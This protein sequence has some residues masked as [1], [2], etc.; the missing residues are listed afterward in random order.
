[1][2]TQT[3]ENS[4]SLGE[5]AHQA[6]RRSFKKLT[7]SEQSVLEDVD[8]EPLHQMR[9]GLRRLR[10]AIQVFTTVVHLPK[11]SSQQRLRS[12]AGTLGVVRDLDVLKATLGE[13]YLHIPASEQAT[14]KDGLKKLQQQRQKGFADMQDVLLGKPYQKMKGSLK[15]WLHQPS[16]Q[17]LAA[18]PI[19]D[20]LPDLL[21]PLISQL[22]L[23]PGWL[24]G[25]VSEQ[26]S[27]FHDSLFHKE[28]EQ[29][30]MQHPELSDPGLILEQHGTVLHSLRKQIKRVR[31]QTELFVE[32]YGSE[33][34]EQIKEFQVIQEVLGQ[35]QD[36]LV[37]QQFLG[38]LLGKNICK[39]LPTL[40][41][42]LQQE[43][44]Q[45]WIVWQKLRSRYLNPEFR[46]QLRQQVLFPTPISLELTQ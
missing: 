29:I 10:T 27:L 9:V 24:V 6:I 37:L 3:S 40:T 33:Y 43:R 17:A 42:Q 23:H 20:A 4:S 16:Y 18:L 5:Y 31:Y 8:P 32:C 21:L 22:L 46:Q 45:A 2:M 13:C 44:Q 38:E 39:A 41:Q 1:M 15:K 7:R 36:S 30:E 12:I 14:L 34:Q 28:W 11:A 19:L 25:A 26:N 35:L